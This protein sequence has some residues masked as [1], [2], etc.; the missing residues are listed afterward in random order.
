MFNVLQADESILDE[1][2]AARVCK[3]RIEHLKEFEALSPTAQNQWQKKRL[4]RM[5]VEYFL[6][7]GYYNSA[8][9]LAHQSGIEVIK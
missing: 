3:R 7:A 1:M 5:L 4:D 2:Q 8:I 9:K 6:R